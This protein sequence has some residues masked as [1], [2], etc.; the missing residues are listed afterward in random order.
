MAYVDQNGLILIDEVEA[1]EDVNRLNKVLALLDEEL[2]K[3]NQISEIN[4]GFKGDTAVAI[5]LSATEMTKK[6]NA[7]KNEIEAEIRYIKAVVER[8]K[9]IDANMKNQINSKLLGEI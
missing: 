4:N 2:T 1:A 3:I 9:T 5:G 8:Y 6:V 7:Q